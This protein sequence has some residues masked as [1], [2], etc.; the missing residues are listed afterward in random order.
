MDAGLLDEADDALVP[1]FV[2]LAHV[3]HQIEQELS[4]QHLVPM[5]PCNIS[6]LWLT[7][8]GRQKV[9]TGRDEVNAS[10]NRRKPRRSESSTG[11]L[12]ICLI[13]KRCISR[14]TFVHQPHPQ[15]RFQFGL[16][17]LQ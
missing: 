10:S 14:S 13:M 4:A 6:E 1:S 17:A 7:C 15:T 12:N 2:L 8:R 16:H 9:D 3:L 5:H 11:Q